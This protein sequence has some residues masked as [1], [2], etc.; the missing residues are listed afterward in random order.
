MARAL[1]DNDLFV[2]FDEPAAAYDSEGKPLTEEQVAFFNQ[3][4][5]LR[6][7]ENL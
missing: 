7:N 6:V 2:D 1:V 3:S 5:C 4:K